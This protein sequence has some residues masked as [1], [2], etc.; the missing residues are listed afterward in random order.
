VWAA[1]RGA[2]VRRAARL[3]S[4]D[5]RGPSARLAKRKTRVFSGGSA[6]G[7]ACR[8][9]ARGGP[10]RRLGGCASACAGV[11]PKGDV[12]SLLARAERSGVVAR[13]RVV[14]SGATLLRS[15]TVRRRGGASETRNGGC[16]ARG[17]GLA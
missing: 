16:A 6:I 15:V 9:R 14:Q 1:L 12:L 4:V 3:R 5:T 11:T 7:S 8:R 13:M 17:M 2:R 10:E